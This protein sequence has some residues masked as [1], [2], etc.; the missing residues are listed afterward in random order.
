MYVCSDDGVGKKSF[1]L[2]RVG[3]RRRDRLTRI[4]DVVT[5]YSMY[6]KYG[7]NQVRLFTFHKP[8]TSEHQSNMFSISYS[9]DLHVTTTHLPNSL[10]YKYYTR[11]KGDGLCMLQRN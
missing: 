2:V 4:S 6:T 3:G 7:R 8:V 1:R 11:H 5:W 10:M 9:I